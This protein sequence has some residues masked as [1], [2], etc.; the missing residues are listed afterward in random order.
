[1]FAKQIKNTVGY[2][3]IELMVVISIITII[4]ALSGVYIVQAKKAAYKITSKYDLHHFAKIEEEF[5]IQHERFIG[6]AGQSIRND[7]LASDF[8]LKGFNPTN[9]V[10]VTIISGDPDDPFNTGDPFI[11]QSKHSAVE[12]SYEFNFTTRQLVEK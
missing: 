5:Y 3:L 4:L 1:M 11:A 8:A 10:C 9:G 6:T 7:G 2:S 12:T